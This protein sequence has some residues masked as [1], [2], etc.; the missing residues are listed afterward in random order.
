MIKTRIIPCLL[1]KGKG[2]V[3]TVK[4]VEPK[5]LGDPMNIVKI[6]N[7]KE[8][9]EIILLDIM[10]TAE[11]RRPNFP[12]LQEIASECFMPLAY[13]GGISSIEDA[14]TAFKVG[15]EKVIINSAAVRNQELIKKASQDFGSQS[16][17][18]SFD[19]KRS[20]LGKYEIFIQN[21]TRGTKLDPVEHAKRMELMGAGELM[22]TSIDRDGTMSGYDIPLVKSVSEAV[23]VPVLASGGAGTLK[24]FGEAVKLG[25]ASGVV[26]GSMF[27]FHGKHRAVLI[28]FPSDQELKKHL[29]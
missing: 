7:E 21:G 5:Y 25:G 3:K 2:L 24:D 10:A 13:G 23:N 19:V 6:F 28:S 29:D 20:F 15:F 4:F 8:A 12:F 17:V 14:S 16:V 26:A 9:H 1:L 18:V 27:V 11:G 22:V